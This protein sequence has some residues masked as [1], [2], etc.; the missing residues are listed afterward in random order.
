MSWLKKSSV[1]LKKSAAKPIYDPADVA[2]L[3]SEMETSVDE[4]K[5]EGTPQIESLVPALRDPN[6]DPLVQLNAREEMDA[7][8]QNRFGISLDEQFEKYLTKYPAFLEKF[9][10][11]EYAAK[12]YFRD[13]FYE[14]LRQKLEKRKTPTQE[15]EPISDANTI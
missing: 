12:E 2:D 3:F 7:L 6:S 10:G 8:L 13:L 9:G 4:S 14:N 11:D 5:F 1:W 15:K